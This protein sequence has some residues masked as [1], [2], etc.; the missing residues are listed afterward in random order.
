MSALQRQLRTVPSSETGTWDSLPKDYSDNL[1]NLACGL[2]TVSRTHLPPLSHRQTLQS[3][4]NLGVLLHLN[5]RSHTPTNSPYTQ[6]LTP[7]F[8]KLSLDRL[9]SHEVYQPKESR[10]KIKTHKKNAYEKILKLTPRKFS[11]PVRSG[12][13]RQK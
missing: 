12:R 3:P 4:S 5:T 2:T 11:V 8:S 7:L 13:Q 1:H 9:P 6:R 10:D